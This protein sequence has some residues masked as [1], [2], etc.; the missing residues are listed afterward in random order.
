MDLIEQA[1]AWIAQDPDPATRQ[2][3]HDFITNNDDE[4]TDC[5]AGRLQFGTAGLR[6]KLGPGPNRMNRVVVMQAAAGLAA[7]I[8][9]H[10][11]NQ[12]SI[13]IGYDA[14]LNSDVFARDTAAIM[15][16]AGINALVLPNALPTPVLAF[17]I[18]HLGTSA[19]VMVTASHNPPQDNGYK[20][21]LGDGCQI[22]PP[23]D[24]DIAREIERVANTM[25]VLEIPTD[26]EWVT[27]GDD[28]LEDYIAR[29]VSLITE[30]Q[31][32]QNAQ[33]TTVITPMHGV[34]GETLHTVLQQAGF[35]AP[36]HVTEQFEPDPNFPTV[37]FPNPEEP[38]A[39]DLALARAT[40][41]QPDLVIAND[42]DA[43][44]CAIAIPTDSGYRML[45][46]DEV[47]SLLGWWATQQDSSRTTLAQSIVSGT[48]LKSI[49]ENAGLAYEHTLTGFKWIGRI[50]TLRFGYE[51]A[52][53]YCVDPEVVS[54]K[55]GISAALF[56]ATT[57]AHLKAQDKNLQDK[58]DDLAKEHGVH[59]TKQV[60]VRVSD[61]ARIAEVMASLR[62]EPPEAIGGLDVTRF[63]DLEEGS[64]LPPTN[65]LLFELAG[66][67]RVIVRPSG[68][69]P[70]VKAYLQAVVPVGTELQ[71]AQT[72]AHQ[73]ITDL[74]ADVRTWLC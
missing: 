14:R 24:A 61:V 34:G 27:L 63:I 8:K 37:A 51:E 39:M 1:Q 69:E 20:V 60:S 71:E 38:G 46:G 21:Y 49:A 7:Y 68:T 42:P 47:G 12:A 52:L 62:N 6:G 36:I 22:V 57:A 10:H 13:V 64:D 54:D 26:D 32:Q 15:Q 53:G 73:Q 43:D 65:G 56:V 31:K 16:G 4:L 25:S 2:E 58:L 67:A 29:T 11:P 44:R 18:Q 9:Q 5:F 3:L 33:V 50:P 40:E 45:T 30:E 23:A 41:Y 66:N 19:G 70:K 72:R 55:D 59:A 35:P 48:M 28:V 17:A 74:E